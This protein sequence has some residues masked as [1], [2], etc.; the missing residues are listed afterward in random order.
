MKTFV[1]KA[2]M[3]IALSF[4]IWSLEAQVPK[5]YSVS[6]GLRSSQ[7]KKIYQDSDGFIWTI[8]DYCLERFDGTSFVCFPHIENNPYTLDNEFVKDIVE[9]AY[10][11]KWITTD[12]GINIYNEDTNSFSQFVISRESTDYMYIT[13][14]S[15][16]I[17]NGKS[18]IL[19]GT[20]R[21]G[22]FALDARTRTIDTEI[23]DNIN[24]NFPYKGGL[25]F[26]DS[27]NRLWSHSSSDRIIAVDLNEMTS[28]IPF[29]KEDV[30]EAVTI[31]A[32]TEDIQGETIYIGTDKGLLIVDGRTYEVRLPKGRNIRNK[33]INSMAFDNNGMKEGK[34]MLYVGMNNYGLQTY[35]SITEDLVDLDNSG[36]PFNTEN[37]KAHYM[38][39]DSQG[40]IWVAAFL[41]GL[42]LLPGQNHGFKTSMLNSQHIAGYNSHCITSIVNDHDNNTVYA[43]SDGGGIFVMSNGEKYRCI[44]RSG[45]ALPS[46]FVVGL[47]LDKR[48]VLWV[49]TYDEGIFFSRTDT[50]FKS[51]ERLDIFNETSP[52]TI[53]Y[54][55]YH[56]LLYIGTH[57]KGLYVL[58]AENG[59]IVDHFDSSSIKSISTLYLDDGGTIWIGTYSDLYF[60]HPEMRNVHIYDVDY[61]TT[62]A[63]PSSICKTDDGCLWIGTRLGLYQYSKDGNLIQEWSEKNGMDS[64]IIK[65]VNSD[66]KGRIWVSTLSGIS[67]INPATGNISNYL[68]SNFFENE[69]KSGVGTIDAEGR[70]YIGGSNGVT[71]FHPDKID[72]HSSSLPDIYITTLKVMGEEIE[73]YPGEEN[74]ILDKPLLKTDFIRIPRN[75]NSFSLTFTVPDYTNY[76]K[77]CYSFRLNGSANADWIRAEGNQITISNLRKRNNRLEIKAFYEGME[78]VG[79]F[80]TISIFIQPKWYRTIAAY[81]AYAFMAVLL[82]FIAV[83]YNL[84]K[85]KQAKS[86]KDAEIN[87]LKLNMFSNLTHEIR[88]PL[89]LVLS[90]LKIMRESETDEKKK[91]TYNLMYRNGLRINRIVNQFMDIRKLDDHQL[92]LYYV[93]T[94]IESFISD[95]MQSFASLARSKSI[96]FRI[97]NSFKEGTLWV[98]PV[99]FDKVIFN[100]LSNAFK[101]VPDEGKITI[102]ISEAGIKEDGKKYIDICISNSGKH[103]SEMYI[104]KIFERFIQEKPL[105]VLSGTGIGL[106][107]AKNLVELHQGKIWAENTPTGVTFVIRMPYGRYH[108][109]DEDLATNKSSYDFYL[110]SIRQDNNLIQDVDGTCSR[111]RSN[112]KR[113][114]I[115]IVDDDADTR[116]Y[117]AQAFRE[118]AVETCRDGEEALSIASTKSTDAIITDLKMDGMDGYELCKRIRSNPS[119]SH[120]PII[121]LTS[122][123][124]EVSEE[125]CS[126]LGADRYFVKPI[127]TTLLRSGVIQAITSRERIV[128]KIINKDKVDY[129]NFKISSADEKLKKK[130]IDIIE[131]NIS[132]SEFSVED[133]GREVGLSRVHLN[134][135][136]K[137]ILNVT[138]SSLIRDMRLKQAAYLLLSTE[139]VNVSEIAY[140]VGYTSP[141]YFS[142]AFKDYYGRSPVLFADYY[143]DISDPD[144]IKKIIEGEYQQ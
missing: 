83:R 79:T 94:D 129:Q 140:S 113:K 49:A 88:T 56:D 139:N 18:Y 111:S 15:H 110:E 57:G 112:D 131:A 141:S 143:S 19:V 11:T 29:I 4:A 86:K 142:V 75:C 87:Q 31:K 95:I 122:S 96:D 69:F 138:T 119:I 3:T 24:D 39:Q 132:N 36:I 52:W 7:I 54:D 47:A 97:F 130:I 124:D 92:K 84:E 10:G 37:I 121:I 63:F 25:M 125:I 91:D 101:H 102:D 76:D 78:N 65:Y 45:S 137:E 46:D 53:K 85:K 103:I 6:S 43:G 30:P 38:I 109:K 22:V 42:I 98:D 107:L 51:F 105:D 67:C 41:K 135:K 48:G 81:F 123:D 64:H 12:K 35:D 108:I 40:N 9:D 20:L 8:S 62:Q 60:Y 90:P 27:K 89:F 133:I 71:S 58:N 120:I 50:G 117:V 144:I 128:N 16:S 77:I 66:N 32:I 26:I 104:E 136:I 106:N 2:S 17:I 61:D 14:L 5:I 23:T 59:Q 28:I 116:H 44:N 1:A 126:E 80:K 114:R 70:I 127:S 118:F 68:S 73:F 34:R 134:R 72:N 100:I 21:H 13:R 55:R 74:Y 82:V 33:V 93:Q 115:I 99:N